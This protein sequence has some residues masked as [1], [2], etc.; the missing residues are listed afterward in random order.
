MVE[1]NRTRDNFVALC[2]RSIWFLAAL[3]DVE[4][5]VKHIPGKNN[6]KADVLSRIYSSTPVDE[7][8]LKNLQRNYM[9]KNIPVQ[10][11]D[12]DLHL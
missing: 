10:Y 9:W 1:T 3:H 12:L 5:E 2:L 7:G 6:Q 11:F 4:I 8:M